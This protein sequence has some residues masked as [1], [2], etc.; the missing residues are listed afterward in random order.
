MTEVETP[1]RTYSKDDIKRFQANLKEEV[2]GAALYR[3]L[4]DAEKDPHLKALFGKL[5]VSEDRHL[6]LWEAKLREAGGA[7][8]SYSPSFRV[9]ALGWIARRFGTHVV[10]PIVTRMEMS[11]VGMYDSQPEAVEHHLPQDERSHARIFRQLSENERAVSDGVDIAKIEGR[12][13]GGSGNALRAAVLGVNDGL[14]TSVSLVMGVAGADPGRSFVFLTGMAGLLAGSFSMA[15]GEWLSVR[16]SAESF[17]R[18]LDIER[19]ELELMP[20]EE[21]AELTL[22]YQAKGFSEAEAQSAAKRILK[23]PQTALDT[24]AREELGMSASDLANPWVAGSTS[25]V[26]FAVGAILPV[27]PWAFIGGATAV[28]ISLVAAGAGLF[29]AGAVTTLFT[30]RSILFSGGRMLVF[31][32]AA[33][34]VT[35]GIGKLIGVNVAA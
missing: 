29:L 35:F 28:V 5:A 3:L 26:L 16:S 25:F 2:D 13:R 24:L 10:T 31:G 33:A 21:E 17:E 18:Q 22:I 14:M 20:E 4:A 9:R 15:L 7:V 1:P 32:L 19:Q 11:A 6:A 12:H 27:L 30:G 23:D 8:P 34:A